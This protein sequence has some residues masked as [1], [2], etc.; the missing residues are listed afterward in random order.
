MTKRKVSKG[1]PFFNTLPDTRIC[2]AISSNYSI[3]GCMGA[4]MFCSVTPW[5]EEIIIV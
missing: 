2:Y 5:L 1:L 3:I 4:K